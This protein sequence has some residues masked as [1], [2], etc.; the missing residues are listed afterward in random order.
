[1]KHFL[2]IAALALSLGGCADFREAVG[3]VAVSSTTTSP[4]QAKTLKDAILLTTAAERSLDLVVKSGLTPAPVLDQLEILVP[5]VHNSLKKAEQ[6]QKDGNS[7]LLAASLQGF[8]EALNAL[9]A[10]KA[11]KGVK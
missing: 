11:L 2:L 6:A 5:V 8:N 4:A 3:D 7:P 10:Y 9:N 1:M